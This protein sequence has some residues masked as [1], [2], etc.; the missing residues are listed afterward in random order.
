M[1]LATFIPEVWS[2]TLLIL[3]KKTF[4]YAQVLANHDYEGEIAGQGDTVHIT[5]ISK[6]T[7][8][9]YTVGAAL[10]YEQLTTADRTL[11]INQAKSFSFEVDDIDKAQAAGSVIASAMELAAY[12]LADATDQYIAGMYNQASAAN[13]LGTVS[14]TTA[15]LAY[16]SLVQL[17]TRLTAANVPMTGRVVVIPPWYEELMIQDARFT[18]AF[19]TGEPSAA[20][21]GFVRR[22]AGFDIFVSNNTVNVTGDD[23]AVIAGVPAAITFA[24]QISQ[25]EALRLQG[26]FA[27]ALRGLHVYG[28]KVV[29]PEAIATVIASQT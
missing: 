24:D 7:I 28:A 20:I 13:Q 22:A 2:A 26:T 11:I 3:L 14:V 4:V 15:D 29:R 8:S 25:V 19:A 17:G 6:P 23:W 12:A 27:D 9:D 1:T 18:N 21:T 10:V 16:K 5:S